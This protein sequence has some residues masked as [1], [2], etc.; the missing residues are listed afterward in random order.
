[1]NDLFFVNNLERLQEYGFEEMGVKNHKGWMR[2]QKHIGEAGACEATGDL[3][4]VVNPYGSANENELVVFLMCGIEED[5]WGA[6]DTLTWSLEEI[7]KMLRDG[8]I[9]WVES[10][11]S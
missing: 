7:W 6:D 1:M 8:V 5:M 10:T 9:E 2:Y 3:Y 11:P 4:L